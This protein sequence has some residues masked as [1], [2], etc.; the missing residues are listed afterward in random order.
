MLGRLFHTQWNITDLLSLYVS[1]LLRL[2]S[3]T[4]K[5]LLF[6]KIR[7][8]ENSNEVKATFK[9][10]LIWWRKNFKMAR[11]FPKK[12]FQQ[13]KNALN[14]LRT[15]KPLLLVLLSR[16]YTRQLCRPIFKKLKGKSSKKS[17]QCNVFSNFEKSV[18]KLQILARFLLRF[19]LEILKILSWP[20]K[21]ACVT[22]ALA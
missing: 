21:L 6:L 20:T 8:N 22:S 2:L 11:H 13:L 19:C 15:W 3:A 7:E 4:Q 1:F 16:I 17:L 10:Y 5:H 14:S 18:N 9:K 12:I